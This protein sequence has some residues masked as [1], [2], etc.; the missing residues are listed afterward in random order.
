MYIKQVEPSCVSNTAWL[1]GCD[2]Q[3]CVPFSV[4]PLCL[5]LAN[6][7]TTDGIIGYNMD[8]HVKN[9]V[10]RFWLGTCS[11]SSN[12]THMLP[13]LQRI[14][15]YVGKH[16]ALIY[17]GLHI[18]YSHDHIIHVLHTCKDQWMYHFHQ[19]TCEPLAMPQFKRYGLLHGWSC[20]LEHLY[21]R[22]MRKTGPL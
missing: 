1:V 13:W 9:E 12:Q 20:P 17:K 4:T 15:I 6:V 7:A 2:V 8:S 16:T 22:P 10:W 18:R 5:H 3:V 11:P 21:T 19:V 14:C